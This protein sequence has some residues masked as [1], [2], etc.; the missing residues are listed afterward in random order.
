VPSTPGTFYGAGGG[1][2][3]GVH[4]DRP[5]LPAH[6]WGPKRGFQGVVIIAYDAPVQAGGGAI[7]QVGNRII[8]TFEANGVFNIVATP[9]PPPPQKTGLFPVF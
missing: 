1:G 6:F 5:P 2:G 8:H 3:S 9:P 4:G 7:T